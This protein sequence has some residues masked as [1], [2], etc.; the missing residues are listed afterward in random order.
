MGFTGCGKTPMEPCFVSGHDFSRAVT[1]V[2]SAGP[3]GPEKCFSSKYAE[4][5]FFR[6]LFSPYIKPT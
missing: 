1:A 6:S 2:K 3:L 5:A 4:F